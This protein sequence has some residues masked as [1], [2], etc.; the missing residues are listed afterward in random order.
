MP[1]QVNVADTELKWY[2][3]TFNKNKRKVVIYICVDEK[4]N[5]ETI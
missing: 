1:R 4:N 5:A 3:L 2:L